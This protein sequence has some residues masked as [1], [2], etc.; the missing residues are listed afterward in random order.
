MFSLFLARKILMI[1]IEK[2]TKFNRCLISSKSFFNLDARTKELRNWLY[3]PSPKTVRGSSMNSSSLY[4]DIHVF[5]CTNVRAKDKKR[6]CGNHDSESL[7]RYL[8]ARCKEMGLKN[9][10]VNSAGCLGRCDV[11]PVMVIYP[12]GIWYRFKDEKDIDLILEEQLMHQNPVPKL[13]LSHED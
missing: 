10:R 11:G 13:K 7:R 6:S 5:I 1:F 4:Y 2:I 9:I 12:Q 3:N 8:K